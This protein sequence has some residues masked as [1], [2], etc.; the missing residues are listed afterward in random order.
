M[1]NLGTT[2]HLQTVNCIK[3]KPVESTYE[4]L[5]WKYL[6]KSVDEKW[7]DWAVEMMMAGYE[8]E[9]LIELAGIEKPF[10]QFE[11]HELIEK[12]FLEL[13]LDYKNQ[14]KIVTNYVTFLAKGVLNGS[15]DMLKTLRDLKDLYIA[16]DYDS[17][18]YGFYSL[19]FAREDLN[20]DTVQWY[21]KGADRTNIDKICT[22]FFTKWIEEHELG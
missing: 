16:L 2:A 3:M 5:A 15:R 12:V 1:S 7:S 10:N 4:I 11:L 20:H 9:H 6:N 18:L 19:Y 8:T 13:N 14:D 21:W 17:K 22:D